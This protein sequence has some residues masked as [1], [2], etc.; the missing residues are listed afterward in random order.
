MAHNPIGSGSSVSVVPGVAS[1]S[2][3][4]SVKSD[5]LR[6]VAVTAGVFLKIDSEPATTSSDYY[7][8]ANSSAT[9]AIT[10]ASQRVVG[11][12][13]GSTTIIDFPDGTGSPFNTGDYVS[14][15]VNN[16]EYYNFI[17]KEVLSVDNSSGV[18]GYFSTRIVVD[19]N[20][21]GIVTAFNNYGDLRKSLKVGTFGA[22]S[23]TLYYQQVQIS[24]DA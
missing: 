3:P 13:T 15:V 19:A 21:S 12:T 16:Q 23:G 9:L 24:G 18:G 20:T 2:E 11:V 17:H 14:L 10:P 6:V 4:F 5:T 22:G 8:P 7:V 1:T